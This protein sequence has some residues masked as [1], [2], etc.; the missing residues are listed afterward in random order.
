MVDPSCYQVKEGK[1]KEDAEGHNYI[2]GVK[3]SVSS[4]NDIKDQDN[5]GSKD[6][7]E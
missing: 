5:H 1:G 2:I 3:M 6:A 7:S 4:V